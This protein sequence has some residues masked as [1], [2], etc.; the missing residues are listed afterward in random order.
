MNLKDIEKNEGMFEI[1]P[2]QQ[3]QDDDMANK[4][5]ISVTIRNMTRREPSCIEDSGRTSQQG[6]TDRLAEDPTANQEH[7]TVSDDSRNEEDLVMKMEE[8]PLEVHEQEILILSA[9]KR[10]QKLAFNYLKAAF[11]AHVLLLVGYY[12]SQRAS[13]YCGLVPEVFLAWFGVR[14]VVKMLGEKMNGFK[15]TQGFTRGD[16]L[17]SALGIVFVFEAIANVCFEIIGFFDHSVRMFR[18]ISVGLFTLLSLVILIATIFNKIKIRTSTCFVIFQ[19]FHALV[20][21]A[22]SVENGQGA[23]FENVDRM[24]VLYV[25]A[26]AI[27]V[28]LVLEI[29]KFALI[30]IQ[31]ILD[32]L[33]KSMMV[34]SGFSLLALIYAANWLLLWVYNAAREDQLSSEVIGIVAHVSVYV[35]VLMQI[36]LFLFYRFSDKCLSRD[37]IKA[38]EKV[39]GLKQAN[40]V[41]IK[42]DVPIYLKKRKTDSYFQKIGKSELA[43]INLHPKGTEKPLAKPMEHTSN[44]SKDKF[45]VRKP[46]GVKLPLQAISERQAHAQDSFRMSYPVQAQTLRMQYKKPVTLLE[47]IQHSFRKFVHQTND[48]KN[49]QV[50]LV[51]SNREHILGIKETES[52]NRIT[53]DLNASPPNQNKADTGLDIVDPQMNIKQTQQILSD[54]IS[55]RSQISDRLNETNADCCLICY[56]NKSAVIIMPCGHSDIC[57]ECSK[58]I[59]TVNGLCFICQ[60]GIN[61]LLVVEPVTEDVYK[62]A[63][64]LYL[65][66]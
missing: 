48:K 17:V 35:C 21:M 56:A 19:V 57:L 8:E 54:N 63:Y 36:I 40:R 24:W 66:K 34:S 41:K 2:I 51:T 11:L 31:M 62:V 3:L 30:S 4:S 16:K 13:L 32:L 50:N 43:K 46:T 25:L 39:D 45:I 12:D 28:L 5:T 22:F 65:K 7:F 44:N 42:A 20:A 26:I 52:E 61:Y 37:I 60:S 49:S 47:G 15:F 9:H 1:R 59:W 55:E 58:D 64:S 14:I 27:T 6:F 33:P 18:I 38:T 23:V 29:I 10:N 53:T